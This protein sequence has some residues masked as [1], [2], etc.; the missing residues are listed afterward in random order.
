MS[1]KKASSST[2]NKSAATPHRKSPASARG[3]NSSAS[4]KTS[5]RTLSNKDIGEVAGEIWGLLATGDGQTLAAIKKSIDAPPDVVAAAIG[6]LAR[7][8]KLEFD[9]TG[10][11]LKIVLRR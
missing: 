6:W 11:T 2:A 4:P 1:A 8:D 9:V 3:T 5:E 10:R 7:E